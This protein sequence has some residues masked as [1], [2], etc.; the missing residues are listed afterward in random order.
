[1]QTTKKLLLCN[2]V[3][4]WLSIT[5]IELER[6]VQASRLAK[7]LGSD[8]LSAP[9]NAN[10]SSWHY[11]APGRALHYQSCTDELITV[12]CHSIKPANFM[13][14]T[15]VASNNVPDFRLIDLGL[16]EKFDPGA[17]RILKNIGAFKYAPAFIRC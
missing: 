8:T 5:G 6:A 16:I 10:M 4:S 17:G 12:G 13:A 1:M 3:Y 14:N 15:P 2:P 7:A 11:I 9:T